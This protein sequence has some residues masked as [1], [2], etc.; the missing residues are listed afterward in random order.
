MNKPIYL[1]KAGTYG[2]LPK[3]VL[4]SIVPYLTKTCGNGSSLHSIGREAN[5][6][7][8]QATVTIKSLTNADNIYYTSG[9]SE[10]NNW[11]INNY[12][13]GK[14][15]SSTIEHH[16]ILNTLKYYAENYGLEYE[17][18]NVDGSGQIKMDELEKALSKGA[19]LCS[20]QTVN[21]EIGTIQ[22]INKIYELCQK[23]NCDF[24]TD[25]TQA[26]SHIDISNL[27]YD[28]ASI[29]AHKFGGLQGIGALLCNK[30]IKPFIIGGEQQDGIR[31]GTYNLCGIVSMGKA[32]ELY[33]YSLERDNRC[34]KIRA[35]FYNAFAKMTD[36]YFNTDIT[37][38]I[39][40]TLN[41]S[42]KG[43]E[44]ESLM[45]LL[46]MDDIYVSSGSA[47]NSGSLE[48]SHVL[49][50]IGTPEE[51]IYNSIRL[52]WDNTLTDKEVDYVIECIKRN[53]KKVRG[54]V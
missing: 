24:H 22:N 4:K 15:I 13:N 14:I 42:F 19:N 26:F 17:L 38:S 51:Y 52:S 29:S 44:S 3:E 21:N 33:N 53:V 40:S 39:S 43:V 34:R 41:I 20:I 23:Y 45:L 47:C 2:Y 54:Y 5:N 49:K 30:P 32:A 11:V 8:K 31:G 6:A 27:K 7:I 37:N 9:S 46:D 48:P 18:V 28:Y 35:K 36:V 16:S 10:S 1:D 12:R 25:L 50:A